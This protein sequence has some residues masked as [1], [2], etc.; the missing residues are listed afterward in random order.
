M[1]IRAIAVLILLVFAGPAAGQAQNEQTAVQEERLSSEAIERYLIDAGSSSNAATPRRAGGYRGVDTCRYAHDGECD[2]PGIGTGACA[3]GTDYSDCWRLAED[4]EDDSCEWAGDGI[5]DEPGFG[6]GACVQGSD[7]SDCDGSQLLRFRNDSCP[8]AF[9]GVCNEPGLGDASC[10]A[11]TDRSDCVGR[12]R[13]AGIVDHFRGHDDRQ[14]FD[15]AELPFSAIGLLRFNAGGS[16][17]ATLVAPDIV[18]TAAHC[19]FG[20]GQLDARARFQAGPQGQHR[21]RVTAYFIDPAFNPDLFFNVHD[22]DGHDWALLRLNRSL[23]ERL[24]YLEPRALAALTSL[25]ITQAGY[26]WDTGESLSGHENCAILEELPRNALIHDCDTTRQDSGAPLLA[27]EDGRYVIIGVD[28]RHR[29]FEGQTQSVNIAA[30]SDRWPEY[31][32]AFRAGDS[33][34]ERLRGE[35][36]RSFL[37]WNR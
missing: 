24:G 31:L 14:L 18:L 35:R 2:D 32:D 19:L 28:S 33:G 9:D 20:S 22:L 10:P 23:G 26:S 11:R 3:R 36:R 4:L 7:I 30:R 6:T 12:A 37:P 27:I 21:A 8:T 17:T 1:L 29:R 34:S 25:P 16:C 15:T 13:P 5:C